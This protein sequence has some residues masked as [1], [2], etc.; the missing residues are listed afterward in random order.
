MLGKWGWRHKQ[1]THAF[2]VHSVGYILREIGKIKS[3]NL[4]NPGGYVYRILMNPKPEAEQKT[5]IESKILADI[6]GDLVEVYREQAASM[7]PED[8]R[9]FAN[10]LRK[11]YTKAQKKGETLFPGEVEATANYIR[12]RKDRI[13]K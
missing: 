6:P 13:V 5:D 7:T 1:I 2:R 10:A 4:T 9:Y 3:R 11:R 12:K 8:A